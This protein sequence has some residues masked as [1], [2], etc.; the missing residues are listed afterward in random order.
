MQEQ[1]EEAQEMGGRRH[2]GGAADA[3]DGHTQV[4]TTGAFGSVKLAAFY[5][6]ERF[7]KGERE[8]QRSRPISV[9]SLAILH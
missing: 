1:H 2:H 9:A 6:R 4:G 5:F 3:A 8:R 7:G